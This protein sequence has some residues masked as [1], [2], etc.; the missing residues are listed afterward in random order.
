MK[1][2]RANT[3]YNLQQCNNIK[4]NILECGVYEMKFADSYGTPVATIILQKNDGGIAVHAVT[5]NEE[6]TIV[7]DRVIN[8]LKRKFL[9]FALGIDFGKCYDVYAIMLQSLVIAKITVNELTHAL[10]VKINPHYTWH[11]KMLPQTCVAHDAPDIDILDSWG[12][13]HEDHDVQTSGSTISTNVRSRS[14]AGN[15]VGSF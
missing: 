6:C 4:N 3:M 12:I 7:R 15:F 1:I 13:D 8:T 9:K 10:Q 14:C 2:I 11:I 5:A